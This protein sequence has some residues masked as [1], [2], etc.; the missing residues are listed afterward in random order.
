MTTTQQEAAIAR[1]RKVHEYLV[2]SV[3]EADDAIEAAQ[4]NNWDKHAECWANIVDLS[5]EAV[6]AELG[7]RVKA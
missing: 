7:P 4:T 2:K 3:R 5:Y 1:L 6:R